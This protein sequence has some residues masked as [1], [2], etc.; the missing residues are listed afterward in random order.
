MLL[1]SFIFQ[2]I[3]ALF[4]GASAQLSYCTYA[5]NTNWYVGFQNDSD[6]QAA[7]RH[8]RENVCVFRGKPIL[9]KKFSNYE[10][11]IAKKIDSVC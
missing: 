3:T 6:A 2:E 8:L 9:V 10:V 11:V 5:G 1:I 7:Y 4:D